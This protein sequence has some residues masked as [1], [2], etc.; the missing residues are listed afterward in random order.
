[1][2]ANKKSV[3]KQIYKSVLPKRKKKSSLIAITTKLVVSA[4]LVTLVSGLFLFKDKF[5]HAE[6]FLIYNIEK[7]IEHVTVEIG[8][9]E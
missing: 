2:K 4:I 1:M 9:H 5:S 7:N 3:L 8:Q 6:Y